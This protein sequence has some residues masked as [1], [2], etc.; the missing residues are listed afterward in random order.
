M[1]RKLKPVLQGQLDGLCGIYAIINALRFLGAVKSHDEAIEAF[2]SIVDE[3]E[4]QCPLNERILYGTEIQE[5]DVVMRKIVRRQY[6]LQVSTPFRS[7]CAQVT[8][9][10]YVAEARTFLHENRGIIFTSLDGFHDHWTLIRE[11]T[12]R[13]FL[14]FDSDRTYWLRFSNTFV[15]KRKPDGFKRFHLLT[16]YDTH[17]LWVE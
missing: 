7:R 8:L 1:S 16:P 17:F 12:D 10:S 5:I 9:E 14:L 15:S 6:G 4:H 13:S 11:V 2:A 3:L